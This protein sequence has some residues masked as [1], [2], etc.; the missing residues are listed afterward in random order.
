LG[1][2]SPLFGLELLKCVGRQIEVGHLLFALLEHG[3]GIDHLDVE[4]VFGAVEEIPEDQQ[5]DDKRDPH[6]FAQTG[7]VAAAFKLVY[8]VEQVV[9]FVILV[10]IERTKARRLG[11]RARRTGWDFGNGHSMT[12]WTSSIR[13]E[14]AF[15]PPIRC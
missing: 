8:D 13:L 3:G 15:A 2:S 1:L 6:F 14:R 7:P 5:M 9:E 4:E 12:V 10:A 11:W